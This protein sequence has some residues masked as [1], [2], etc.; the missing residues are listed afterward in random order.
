MTES[1]RR[2]ASVRRRTSITVVAALALSLPLIGASPS[3]AV[4]HHPTGLYKPFADCPL[5]KE[6]VEI[7]VFSETIGGEFTIGKSKRRVP[8]VNPIELQ[9]GYYENPTTGALTFYGAEDGNTLTK[10]AQPVP[11]GLLG[12]VASESLPKFLQEIINK[13]VSEGLAGVNATAELA[14]PA[15]A[16]ALNVSNLVFGEGVALQLPLKIKLENTL[17]GNSC[18][19]GSESDPVLLKLTTGA[20]S[21]PGPNES[22]KGSVGNL[23]ILEGGNLVRFTENSLVDNAFAAPKATGCGGALALLIDPAVNLELGLSA[24]GGYNTARLDGTIESAVST[25]VEN[26]E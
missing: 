17:L 4:E 14:Q 23:S 8:I 12:V 19:I 16:I 26:S 20:T 9:G 15:S 11:G 25:A 10:T 3:L 1:I 22:I 13:L 18:Y 5:S 7:C 6:K 24:P 2:L 21:P